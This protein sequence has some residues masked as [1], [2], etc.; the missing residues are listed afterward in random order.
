MKVLHDLVAV[1]E[2]FYLHHVLYMMYVTESILG[3]MK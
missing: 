2:E 1:I 3:K